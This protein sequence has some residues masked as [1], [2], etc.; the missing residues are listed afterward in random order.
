MGD[1]RRNKRRLRREK[2]V[3]ETL[4]LSGKRCGALLKEEVWY[5]GEQL[6][7]YGLAYINPRT[8]DAD[9]GR[10]LGYDNTHDYHHRHFMGKIENIEFQSY[11]AVLARFEREV[12]ALWKEEDENEKRR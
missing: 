1:A 9:N 5:E 2:R 10:V 12:R 11:E 6:V 3:D 7:K 4:Y 8:C